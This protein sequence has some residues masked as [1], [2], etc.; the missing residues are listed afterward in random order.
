[1]RA[2]VTVAAG[3][4]QKAGFIEYK[5]G[6]IRIVDRAGLEGT[7]CLCYQITREATRASIIPKP[8]RTPNK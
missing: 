3:V 8:R 7:S 1:V 4:L 2:G 5:H 6:R